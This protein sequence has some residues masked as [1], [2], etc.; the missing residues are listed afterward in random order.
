MVRGT[1]W[2]GWMDRR[3]V[4][5]RGASPVTEETRRHRGAEAEV[6]PFGILCLLGCGNEMGI[7]HGR[8]WG[9]TLDVGY[10]RPSGVVK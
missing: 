3:E 2:V 10:W 8:K 5:E 4:W 6:R 7:V 9:S 1:E